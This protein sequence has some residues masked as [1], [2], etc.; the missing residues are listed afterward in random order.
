M[1][2]AKAASRKAPVRQELQSPCYLGHSRQAWQRAWCTEE[3]DEGAKLISKVLSFLDSWTQGSKQGAEWEPTRKC[4]TQSIKE[5]G[6]PDLFTSGGCLLTL[7]HF[8][9]RAGE[10][11][12]VIGVPLLG[13]RGTDPPPKTPVVQMECWAQACTNRCLFSETKGPWT[14]A[15]A[16]PASQ[17]SLPVAHPQ[18]FSLR[19]QMRIRRKDF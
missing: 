17:G 18:K 12:G 13:V 15:Q 1:G 16:G 9:L 6:N 5:P 4:V 8:L 14:T 7:R 19:P 10:V 3:A 2:P 11:I